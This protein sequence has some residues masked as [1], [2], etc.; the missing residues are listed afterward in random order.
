METTTPELARDLQ[1]AHAGRPVVSS[2]TPT[3]HLA[4]GEK[5]SIFKQTIKQ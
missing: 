4:Y 2:P 1:I 3:I 5:E